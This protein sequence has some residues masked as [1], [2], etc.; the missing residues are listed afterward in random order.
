[1]TRRE[2]ELSEVRGADGE[3]EEEGGLLP[4][5]VFCFSK[6]K[7]EEII[8]FFKGQDLLSSREKNEVKKV[9]SKA[10]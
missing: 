9:M 7:C 10:S 5:V 8:D 2:Y 6:K 1:M 4:V 3:D